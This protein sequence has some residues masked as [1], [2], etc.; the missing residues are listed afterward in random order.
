MGY[1]LP[2][3]GCNMIAQDENI[4]AECFEEQGWV[5][6]GKMLIHFPDCPFSPEAYPRVLARQGIETLVLEQ[7]TTALELVTKAFEL[8][9]K[10][11]G[12]FETIGTFIY[13]LFGF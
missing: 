8:H 9:A 12:L 6:G 10:P 5:G 1:P 11:R 7:S 2:C 4:A 13:D 3:V